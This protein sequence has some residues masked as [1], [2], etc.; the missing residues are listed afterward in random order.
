MNNPELDELRKKKLEE[1]QGRLA[2]SKHTESEA[3]R[4]MGALALEGAVKA[5]F[6]REALQRFGTLK[7][8]HPE[9][10]AR[11]VMVLAH[12]IESGKLNGTLSEEQLVSLLRQMSQLSAK[13]ET[14]IIRR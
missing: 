6:S 5:H 11:L 8:A 12:L 10:A 4:Q 14:K 3:A 7:I 9:T 1:L 2:E 13:K